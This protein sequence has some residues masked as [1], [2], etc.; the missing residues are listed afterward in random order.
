VQQLEAARQALQQ[1][2]LRMTPE[3][4]DIIRLKRTI[5]ALEKKVDTEAANAPMPTEKPGLLATS[6]R[7]A[8]RQR[9]VRETQ[10][11]MAS[12]DRQ[13]A[14]SAAEEKK[15]RETID[16]YQARVEAAPTRESELIA[17]TRDYD[18]G[19]KSYTSLL[20]KKWDSQI[21]A[22]LERRQIG[23]QFKVL[24]PA[25]QPE[26][27]FSPNRRQLDTTGALAGLALGLAL[28]ALREFANSSLK[29]DDD[30]V[31]SLALPVLAMI[32]MMLSRRDEQRLARRRRLAVFASSV[33][34]AVIAAG[35]LVIWKFRA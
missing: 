30:V 33:A 22:N 4:P 32:P 19:Q 31:Q 26:R 5:A 17:L 3:H 9:R 1:M 23:E 21:A 10:E 25:R 12:L 15:I 6:A 34:A 13:L 14:R 11:E 35:V 8:N 29:V 18:T 27:P 20:T 16:L 28:V 7:E 24:D 2:S